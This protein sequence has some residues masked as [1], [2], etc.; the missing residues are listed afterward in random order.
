MVYIP[1]ETYVYQ[2]GEEEATT[3]RFE[4]LKQ[5]QSLL[6]V[7]EGSSFFEVLMWGT[8]WRVKKR[9]VYGIKKEARNDYKVN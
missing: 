7:G 3:K 1:S 5:P 4:K 9:D 2:S 8:P 6:V